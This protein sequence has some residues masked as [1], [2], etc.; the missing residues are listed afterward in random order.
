V[1]T[2]CEEEVL[3]LNIPSTELSGVGEV[4]HIMRKIFGCV[5]LLRSLQLTTEE[6]DIIIPY[7]I[8]H[9]LWY[10]ASIW[11]YGLHFDLTLRVDRRLIVNVSALQDCWYLAVP[12]DGH[13]NICM[14]A[15][16][17]RTTVRL[18]GCNH[19]YHRKCIFTWFDTNASCHICR[20]N[21]LAR[22]Y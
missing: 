4:L 7:D 13:C 12:E 16:S 6:W 17:K 5:W 18:R 11:V 22:L 8:L 19:L 14:H 21:V 15:L 1:T 2:F 3:N 9:R 20:D 10:E